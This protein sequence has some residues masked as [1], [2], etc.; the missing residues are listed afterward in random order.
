MHFM[1][2]TLTSQKR[3]KIDQKGVLY[4]ETMSQCHHM[5]QGIKKRLY[6]IK[7]YCLN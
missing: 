6:K 5:Y 1:H 2:G 7:K 4:R 3:Q